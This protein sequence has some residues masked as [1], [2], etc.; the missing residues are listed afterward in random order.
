[1]TPSVRSEGG[2]GDALPAPPGR[3]RSDP[4]VRLRR[5]LPADASSFAV[6]PACALT[7]GIPVYVAR[8]DAERHASAHTGADAAAAITRALASLDAVAEADR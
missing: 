5:L 8:A 7:L 4:T 2:G 1:M 6:C 3:L